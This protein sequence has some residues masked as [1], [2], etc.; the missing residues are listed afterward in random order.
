MNYKDIFSTFDRDE[1]RKSKYDIRFNPRLF[2]EETGVGNFEITNLNALLG[3]LHFVRQ[4]PIFEV[5]EFLQY[6]LDNSKNP[7]MYFKVLKFEIVP[8]LIDSDL[9]HRANL[10]LEW[11]KECKTPSVSKKPK[12]IIIEGYKRIFDRYNWHIKQDKMSETAAKMK[13]MADLKIGKTKFYDAINF[14]K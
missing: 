7:K 9:E 14:H 2:N 12:E 5:Y 3:F 11:V 1:P 4:N 13:V 10:V 6:H 8:K